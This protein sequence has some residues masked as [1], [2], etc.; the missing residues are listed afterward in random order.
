MEN[1]LQLFF[2]EKILMGIAPNNFYL[3]ILHKNYFYIFSI[4][5]LKISSIYQNKN[6]HNTFTRINSTIRGVV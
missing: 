3:F 2:V 6:I 1:N 4:K 5:V